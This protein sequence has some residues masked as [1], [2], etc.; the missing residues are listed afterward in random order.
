M[1]EDQNAYWENVY[2]KE[3]VKH[4]VYDGWLDQYLPILKRCQRILDLGCGI[5]VNTLYLRSAGIQTTAC[6]FSQSALDVLVSTLPDAPVL[7]FDMT[8]GLPFLPESIDAIIADLSLH[9]FP[10]AVTRQIV[11]DMKKV[12]RPGGLLLCRVNAYED[13]FDPSSFETI[14]KDYYTVNECTKRFFTPQTLREY[15]SGWQIIKVSDQKTEKYG[16]VKPVIFAHL[17]K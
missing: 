9:Y 15:F 4:P 2:T 13:E 17:I 16:F 1:S 14:D 8:T 6:D 10:D 7:C 5:G 11:A 12:L 3:T